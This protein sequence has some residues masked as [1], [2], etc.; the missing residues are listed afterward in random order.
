[1]ETTIV[2]ILSREEMDSLLRAKWEGM[3]GAMLSGDIEVA[4]T[5]FVAGS[6]D[7]YRQVFTELGSY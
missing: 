3:K 1:M 2:N 6:R 7:R 5:Y 4:L